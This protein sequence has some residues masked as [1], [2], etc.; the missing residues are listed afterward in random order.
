MSDITESAALKDVMGQVLDVDAADLQDD[1]GPNQVA[2]WTSLKHLELVVS[3]EE[4]YGVQLSQQD[5]KAMR[6][7]AAVREILAAHGVTA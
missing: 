1:S 4:V 7:V 2:G 6:S 5:I 3:L